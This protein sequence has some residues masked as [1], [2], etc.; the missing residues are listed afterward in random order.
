MIDIVDIVKKVFEFKNLDDAVMYLTKLYED[1]TA[2][3]SDVE[4]SADIHSQG[5]VSFHKGMFS[6]NSTIYF[7]NGFTSKYKTDFKNSIPFLVEYIRNNRIKDVY[8]FFKTITNFNIYYLGI[9]AKKDVR[10]DFLNSKVPID[11]ADDEYF[12][13]ID[14]FSIEDFKGRGIGMC[15]EFSAITNIVLSLFGI[16]CYYVSGDYTLGDM[17]DAHAYN[18]LHLKDGYYILDTSNPHCMYNSSGKLVNCVNTMKK[19]DDEDF[20]SFLS[21]NITVGVRMFNFLYNENMKKWDKVDEKMGLY[22]C[23]Y[24]EKSKER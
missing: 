9:T 18:I 5:T 1:M 12:K 13:I 8:S 2:N 10:E 20:N 14:S 21:G 11:A 7:S 15:T 23:F 22:S 6:R 16:E 3:V 4:F 24:K 19:I 17:K